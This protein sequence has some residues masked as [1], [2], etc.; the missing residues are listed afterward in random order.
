MYKEVLIIVIT[1]ILILLLN[2]I[3]QNYTKDSVESLSGILYQIREDFLQ[4]EIE[5]EKLNKDI[6]NIFME[7]ENRH[8]TLA[9]YIEH[10]ELEKVEDELTKVKSNILTEEYEQGV[11]HLDSCVFLLQH[12]QDK[13][14]FSLKN[15]F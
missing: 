8:D 15:I 4:E 12:I 10:D 13:E 7:W 1:I 6:E 9:Y 3:T 11:E 2:N 5:Q 14:S